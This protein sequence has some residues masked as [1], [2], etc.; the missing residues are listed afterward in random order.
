MLAMKTILYR[1]GWQEARHHLPKVCEDLLRPE[2]C[3][4][5][6]WELVTGTVDCDLLSSKGLIYRH[7][8]ILPFAILSLFRRSVPFPCLAVAV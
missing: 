8:A 1:I 5:K 7:H 6:L 2:G 3:Q 4:A